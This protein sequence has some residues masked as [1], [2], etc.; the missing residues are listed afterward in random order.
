MAFIDKSAASSAALLA[1]LEY[2]N[3]YYCPRNKN[4]HRYGNKLAPIKTSYP[5]SKFEDIIIDHALLPKQ[6]LVFIQTI[7]HIYNTH[8][9][10]ERFN[11]DPIMR[12]IPDEYWNSGIITFS[13]IALIL[14]IIGQ[15]QKYYTFSVAKEFASSVNSLIHILV[16]KLKPAKLDV[17]PNKLVLTLDDKTVITLVIKDKITTSPRFKNKFDCEE[18]I[19]N[20]KTIL[21]TADAL[22]SIINGVIYKIPFGFDDPLFMM[23][24]KFSDLSYKL[25]VIS[26]YKKRFSKVLLILLFKCGFQLSNEAAWY[27][28]PINEYIRCNRL[29]N[30]KGTTCNGDPTCKH[31]DFWF[32]KSSIVVTASAINSI[33]LISNMV[34]PESIEEDYNSVYITILDLEYEETNKPRIAG[35]FRYYLGGVLK[36]LHF[37]GLTTEEYNKHYKIE[38]ILEPH[39]KDPETLLVNFPMYS[40][41]YYHFRTTEIK[42]LFRVNTNTK[43]TV[44]IKD[45]YIF[46]HSSSSN[47]PKSLLAQVLY[48]S[49]LKGAYNDTHL[50]SQLRENKYSLNNYL[51]IA[52]KIQSNILAFI[53]KITHLSS[54]KL[55]DTIKNELTEFSIY[56]ITRYFKIYNIIDMYN[57][58]MLTYEMIASCLNYLDVNIKP[59]NMSSDEFKVLY[60]I[61][62][63][64]ARETFIRY[65]LRADTYY[66]L[67]CVYRLFNKLEEYNKIIY[68]NNIPIKIYDMFYY[69][70]WN[71]GDNINFIIIKI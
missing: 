7:P 23:E 58:Q 30:K 21:S 69:R 56:K 3:L 66:K 2:T 36:T 51:I 45:K 42:K 31:S 46:P 26:E 28:R 49:Y 11:K 70:K 27:L 18:I 59:N 24:N 15:P 68:E 41:P 47:K 43:Q 50:Y 17:F 39:T 57:L 55:E 10:I 9:V 22:V 40:I 63:Y 25:D 52:N 20:G 29:I 19:Y 13:G 6:L 35:S 71:V 67:E 60:E 38:T 34:A 4:S 37:N 12:S 44:F 32:E 8:D 62:N 14:V 64:I 1:T 53:N 33:H 5:P 54:N 61:L 48:Q 65:T 16:Q